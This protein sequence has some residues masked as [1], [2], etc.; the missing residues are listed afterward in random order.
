MDAVVI[1]LVSLAGLPQWML[2]HLTIVLC[3][4]LN[5]ILFRRRAKPMVQRRSA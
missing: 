4:Q 1:I 5:A 2:V 3:S